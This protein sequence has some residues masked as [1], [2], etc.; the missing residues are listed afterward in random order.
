MALPFPP[1]VRL[2]DS[3]EVDPPLWLAPMEGVTDPSFRG[4]VLDENPGAVGAAC[5]EFVRVTDHPAP[6]R[7]LVEAL[8]PARSDAAVGL[9]LMGNHPEA[10]AASAVRAAEAG[11]A[12]LDLN[13]GCPAPRVFQHCAGSALLADPPLL[14][15]MVRATVEACPVPVTAKIR[16]GIED[17]AGIE[18]IARRVEQAGASALA[19][20]ARLKTDRYTDPSRW[21]RISRAVAAVHIP[22]IGNGSAHKPQDIQAMFQETGCAGVM[23]AR[24][25]LQNPWVFSDWSA[26][27]RGESPPERGAPEAVD[28]LAR[29]R[30]RMEAGG[31][32]PRQALG[33]LKQS[34][35]ALAEAG[36]LDAEKVSPALRLKETDSFLDCLDSCFPVTADSPR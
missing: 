3:L 6:A 16:S 27:I 4:M 15:S 13:F 5:T 26:L 14:E 23:V 17:D 34:A 10:V 31:A 22:V 7:F 29:Y 36:F 35:K 2:G 9:Q 30:T 32:T 8:G 19:I 24:G 18:D 1:A 28:W 12:F 11:A 21:Q 25:A 20:H 33:R